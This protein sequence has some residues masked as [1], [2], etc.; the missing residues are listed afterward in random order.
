MAYT[1]NQSFTGLDP[2]ILSLL[3]H[4]LFK[5]MRGSL[6]DNLRGGGNV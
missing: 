6:K 2:N 1:F 4:E 5:I 3:P